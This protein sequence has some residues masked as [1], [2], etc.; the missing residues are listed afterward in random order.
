VLLVEVPWITFEGDASILQQRR[1]HAQKQQQQQQAVRQ[2][3]AAAGPSGPPEHVTLGLWDEYAV[4]TP[5]QLTVALSMST[6]VDERHVHVEVRDNHFFD[7]SIAGEGSWLLD[8]I[9]AENG[10]AFLGTLN[11]H[12]AAFGGAR[13]ILSRAAGTAAAP[14]AAGAA[15][16]AAAAAPL[17]SAAAAAAANARV[18][19]SDDA[20]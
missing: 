7:V 19:R 3:L 2:R 4:I 20:R 16:A 1:A 8:V 17:A 12:S 6:G 15:A 14:R 11:Q 18:A 10:D 13:M 5:M 9:N